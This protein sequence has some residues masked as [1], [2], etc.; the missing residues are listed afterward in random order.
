MSTNDK[1][2]RH[3]QI[4]AASFFPPSKCSACGANVAHWIDRAAGRAACNG[5]GAIIDLP[6]LANDKPAGILSAER[7]TD[8]RAQFSDPS[9]MAAGV[10]PRVVAA[11]LAHIDALT[12][13]SGEVDAEALGRAHYERLHGAELRERLWPSLPEHVRAIFIDAAVALRA[14]G[15]AAGLLAPR[16]PGA[17]CEGCATLRERLATAE[18]ERDEAQAEAGALVEQRQLIRSELRAHGSETT[19]RAAARLTAKLAEARAAVEQ[20][21]AE[22]AREEREACA[23]AVETYGKPPAW[24]P[25][26]V[27]NS[28]ADKL[29]ARG[30]R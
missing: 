9:R 5:C 13:P 19:Q 22:G 1:P 26:D 6:A 20:A 3:D 25:A 12:P 27:A 29:R 11:L 30:A 4:R 23:C 14:E 16:P 17:T 2:N 21:R 28:I 7:L 15:F 24:I 8:L 18:R 10:E